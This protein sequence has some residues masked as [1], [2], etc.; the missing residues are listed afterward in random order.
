MPLEDI[1]TFLHL[2]FAAHL[3]V[4]AEEMEQRKTRMD[5]LAEK[6]SYWTAVETGN[7]EA[8][9]LA[10]EAAELAKE[11]AELAKEA[12][13]WLMPALARKKITQ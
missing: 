4:V 6:V 2:L 12:A 8:A 3:A 5:Y 9:E 13:R 10:K 7:I 11:A 1:R